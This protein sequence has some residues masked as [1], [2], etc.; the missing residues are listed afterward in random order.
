MD[1]TR[2][3]MTVSFHTE[4]LHVDA[5]HLEGHE[6]ALVRLRSG[7]IEVDIYTH[8]LAGLERI[9]LELTGLIQTL[10]EEHGWTS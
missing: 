4:D 5:S 8:H 9:Q 10:R 2:A 1:Y 6:T 3:A 7:A